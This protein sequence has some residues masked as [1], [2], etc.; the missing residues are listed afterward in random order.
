MRNEDMRDGLN[1]PLLEGGYIIAWTP[2]DTLG[3]EFGHVVGVKVG[4]HPDCTGWS[5]VYE[6]TVSHPA[7]TEDESVDLRDTALQLLFDGCHPKDVLRE[8]A[9]I[10][11][12]R[13]TRLSGGHWAFFPGLWRTWRP[14]NDPAT[15]DYWDD[16]S[17]R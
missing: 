16:S 11:A 12:W 5:I 3:K 1:E 2:D 8:F 9:R 13:K 14:H 15:D 6:L 17:R 10:P 7:G 4:P